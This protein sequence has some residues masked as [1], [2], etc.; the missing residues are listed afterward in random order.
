D[1]NKRVEHTFGYSPSDMWNMPLQTL[2]KG[3]GPIILAKI[4]E[5]LNE[6]RPIIISGHGIR[7]DGSLFDAE[8]SV[9]K[10]KLARS[11]SL[12]FTVRDITK[13]MLAMQEKMRAQSQAKPA[14]V[15]VAKTKVLRCTQKIQPPAGI[16]K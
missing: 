15:R 7:K 4:I 12:L 14:I 3:F 11:E 13:R 10:V 6:D 8:I 2:I 5:P 16:V 9:S 1:S